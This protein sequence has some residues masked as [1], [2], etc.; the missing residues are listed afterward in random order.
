MGAEEPDKQTRKQQ[1]KGAIAMPDTELRPRMPIRRFDVFAEY[2]RLKGLK[3][4]LDESHAEGYGVWVAKV[5]ASGR[6]GQVGEKKPSPGL[7]GA[8]REP[9][10]EPEKQ[11]WHMLGDE[12]QTAE[13]FQHDIVQRMGERFYHTVFAP[14]IAEQFAKGKRYEQIRD[15]IRKGWTPS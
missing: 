13:T 7:S 14:T 3:Q 5:V 12:P 8:E 15:T 6:R 9:K 1:P 10:R 2:E 11:E 4:G